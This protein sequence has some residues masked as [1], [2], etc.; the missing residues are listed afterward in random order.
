MNERNLRELK[1][2]IANRDLEKAR[3]HLDFAADILQQARKKEVILDGQQIDKLG[4]LLIPD[5]FEFVSHRDRLVALKTTG[6]GNCLYNAI[7]SL[8]C[9]D[10]SL[11]TV[12]RLLVVGE[13]YFHSNFYAHHEVFQRAV[14]M[15]IADE[16]TLLAAAL[17]ADGDNALQKNGS[18]N[19]A[20][21]EEAFSACETGKWSSL[22]TMMALASVISRPIYSVYPE[23]EY[24]FRSMYNGTL[25]PR[26]TERVIQNQM[27]DP[28]HVLWSKE[29]GL[30][31]RPNV[32]YQPNHFVPLANERELVQSKKSTQN[33]K[34]GL[35]QGSI[36][37]FFTSPTSSLNKESSAKEGQCKE[38]SET[39]ARKR[40]SSSTVSSTS[41]ES[42]TPT[43]R[44]KEDTQSQKEKRKF[45][46]KWKD[47]FPWLVYNSG[48]G[49]MTCQL[50]CAASS[51]AGK[52]EFLKGC[53]TFKKETISKHSISNGHIR[54]RDRCLAGQKSAVESEIAKSF[55]KINKEQQYQERKEV[56]AKLNTAYCIAKEEMPFSKFQALISLQRKNGVHLN[57]TYVNEK[58][59]A[60]M[61]AFLSAGLRHDL[62]AE[63]NSKKYFSIMAD[64]STD[65]GGVEN[66]AVLCRFV[67]EGR[68]INRFVGNKAVEHCHAE[69]EF[70][71]CSL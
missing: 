50:C 1:E 60:D 38:K 18:L 40:V 51:V 5:D 35:K 23:V 70:E 27:A 10:E 36:A 13:L 34:V 57:K 43:K 17:S 41:G 42:R 71:L 54:A 48:E 39:D 8:L 22:V 61:V 65:A 37:S 26:P 67:R 52:T 33:P 45:N 46:A 56:E 32:W 64:G 63:L 29:G 44:I 24:R 30:D 59:C 53:R 62:V 14:E 68:P 12:L 4:T 11:S 15:R 9:G 21:K 20:I 55:S 7:S 69:G 2:S 19:E 25:N 28:C 58:S 6:D 66:E 31:T 49:I 3:Q 16:R 47:E